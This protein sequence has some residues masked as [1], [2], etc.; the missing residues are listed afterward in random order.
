MSDEAMVLFPTDPRWRPRDPA[1]LTAALADCGLTG[2]AL[3]GHGPVA[4]LAG[5][6]F[7]EHVCFLG[8]APAVRLAPSEDG[9]PFCHVRL[10][11]RTSPATLAGGPDPLSRP[12]RHARACTFVAI[13]DVHPHEAVPGPALLAALRE[14]SG[15]AWRYAYV[16]LPPGAGI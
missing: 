13:A 5:P 11:T 6:R 1:V 7:L 8:C 15:L 10:V 9:G 3:P 2:G 16:D 12:R 14:T 4:F